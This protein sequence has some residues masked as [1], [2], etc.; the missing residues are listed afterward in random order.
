MIKAVYFDVGGTLVDDSAIDEYWID[1]LLRTLPLIVNRNVSRDEID[2]AYELAISSFSPSLYSFVIWYFVQPDINAFKDLRS[3]FDS[4][5]FS[6]FFKLREDAIEVCED[7][8]KKYKLAIAA[9]QPV[10]TRDFL[11]KEGILK[12]F[13]SFAMSGELPYSK[14]DNRFFLHIANDLD[15]PLEQSVMVGDRQDNDIIPAKRNSMKAIRLVSGKHKSQ[16]IRI[17][18]ELPDAV[19]DTLKQLPSTINDL[20]N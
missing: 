20:Q 12:Y 8:S 10:S 1:Y 15:V 13:K 19:V 5:D 16:I 2:K 18:S 7:L 17:P 11:E 9:N 6:M 4:L 3:Q 14:P